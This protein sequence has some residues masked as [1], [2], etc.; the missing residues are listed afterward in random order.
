MRRKKVLNTGRVE[1]GIALFLIVLLV[2]MNACQIDG[3][4]V[5]ID[6]DDLGGV[7]TSAQ[8]PEAGVW[9]I[10]ETADLPTKFIKIVEV[11]TVHSGNSAAFAAM[12]F[13]S[14]II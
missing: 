8:G 2:G 5:Q 12:N 7:V 10:A 14:K 3:E 13:A 9:V 1:I 11:N 4:A 6:D